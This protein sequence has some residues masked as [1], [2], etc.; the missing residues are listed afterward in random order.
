MCGTEAPRGLLASLGSLFRRKRPESRATPSAPPPAR[1]AAGSETGTGSFAFEVEDVFT[2]TG[3]G[4]VA[5]GR[6]I[7]GQIAKGDEI[8]FRSPQGEVIRRR[9]VGIE[10]LG[11][12]VETA[13]EGDTVG[14]LF[15]KPVAFDVLL[16]G[17][18]FERV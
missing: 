18:V 11:K 3:R 5:T 17:V 16:R 6:V 9:I 8:S 13:K 1:P 10:T 14:L 2:I 7:R 15:T 12:I 4:M